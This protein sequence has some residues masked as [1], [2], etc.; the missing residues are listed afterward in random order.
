[1]LAGILAFYMFELSLSM[2]KKRLVCCEVDLLLEGF[3]L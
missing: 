1:M 3:S 2:F